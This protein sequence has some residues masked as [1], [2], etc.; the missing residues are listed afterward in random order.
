MDIEKSIII[1]VQ[2]EGTPDSYVVRLGDPAD[3]KHPPINI[4]NVLSRDAITNVMNALSEESPVEIDLLVDV[5]CTGKP[6]A[7][8]RAT[9]DSP[10]WS[11]YVDSLTV[12]LGHLDTTD[13]LPCET[14][15]A[16]EDSVLQA[17]AELAADWAEARRD[18]RRGY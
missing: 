11:P 3:T 10:G 13:R 12:Y 9:F 1:T 6:Q 2:C 17:A 18:E 4:A 14:L 8:S 7:G 5:G 15:G 16:V